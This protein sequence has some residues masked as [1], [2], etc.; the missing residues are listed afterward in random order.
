[1]VLAEALLKYKPV[2]GWNITGEINLKDQ[3]F[4]R[5]RTSDY[6]SRNGNTTRP[7]CP[8]SNFT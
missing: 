5:P 6:V 7:T 3:L 8:G 1:M 4:M 2:I